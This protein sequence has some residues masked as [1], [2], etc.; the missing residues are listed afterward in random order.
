MSGTV[1]IDNRIREIVSTI[2]RR[3]NANLA[4][5]EE[6]APVYDYLFA[7]S[8]D[9]DRQSEYVQRVVPDESSLRVLEAGSGTGRLLE[10]LSERCPHADL[11]GVD[12]HGGMVDIARRRLGPIDNVT[13]TRGDFFDVDD[14]YHVV[15][16]FNLLPHVDD[17]RL[18]DFIE[19]AR[20]LLVE[21]G[22][23]ALDYKDPRNNE[24]GAYDRWRD[25]TDEFVIT[26]R[27]TTVYD[28]CPYYAVAYEFDQKRTDDTYRTAELMEINFQTPADLERRLRR[29][30]FDGVTVHRGAGD[31]SG[32]LLATL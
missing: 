32:I 3:P 16:A 15:A 5:Y 21:G 19:H 25:E 24:N 20:S 17:E 27:F 29:G 12:L 8:Y 22:A 13:V 2:E 4:M 31:Q 14:D 30:G 11:E 10:R 1:D 6:L 18:D 23:L 28:D 26:V 9:Y 7:G